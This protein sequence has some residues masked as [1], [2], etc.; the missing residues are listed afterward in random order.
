MIKSIKLKLRSPYRQED[1]FCAD[2]KTVNEFMKQVRRF[3][4]WPQHFLARRSQKEI[5]INILSWGFKVF[6]A[7]LLFVIR[8]ALKVVF[9]CCVLT[10][11]FQNL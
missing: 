1:V 4:S 2:T 11:I 3:F 6:T 9:V 7:P 8:I 5:Q 10:K